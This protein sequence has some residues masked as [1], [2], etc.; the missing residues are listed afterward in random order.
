MQP[1]IDAVKDC[2]KCGQTKPLAAFY[3]NKSCKQ[4]VTGTC[5][6]CSR[7]RINNWYS[8]TRRKRQDSANSRNRS[9]KQM[10]VDYFGGKCMDCG[11]T[12]PNCVFQFHHLDPNEK[13]FNPSYAMAGGEERMWAELKKC[14]MLCANCHLIRH[15]GK[16]ERNYAT[17]N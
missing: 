6:D 12:Y 9:K 10:A 13:D 3:P 16:E 2:R 15:H 1:L 4:G 8:Q 14:V 17:T 5:R 7:E 11:N